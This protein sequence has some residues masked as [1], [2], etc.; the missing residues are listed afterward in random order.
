MRRWYDGTRRRQ[1]NKAMRTA[2]DAFDL[3]YNHSQTD[4]DLIKHTEAV[5]K[6]LA[7]V[8]RHARANRYPT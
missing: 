1:I 5:S 7:E 8:R 6:A 4:A 3:A 2:S